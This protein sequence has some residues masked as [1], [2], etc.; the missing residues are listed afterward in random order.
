MPLPPTPFRDPRLP[1]SSFDAPFG[2]IPWPPSPPSSPE[3]RPPRRSGS[4]QRPG[5]C[6]VECLFLR[7]GRLTPGSSA[8]A[9]TRYPSQKESALVRRVRRGVPPSQWKGGG[10]PTPGAAATTHV[11]IGPLAFGARVTETRNRAREDSARLTTFQTARAGYPLAVRFAPRPGND[12]FHTRQMVVV[13]TM[14]P[15]NNIYVFEPRV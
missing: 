5:T 13:T 9:G 7:G 2:G 6:G 14:D 3:P 11:G 1:F 10:A 12:K 8:R 4:S 15:S